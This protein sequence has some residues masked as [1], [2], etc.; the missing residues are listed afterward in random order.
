MT[1]FLLIYMYRIK[2]CP[3]VRSKKGQSLFVPVR[4][5]CSVPLLNFMDNYLPS[6]IL[7]QYRPNPPANICF[8][9]L[10]FAFYLWQGRFVLFLRA[11]FVF[12][13]QATCWMFFSPAFFKHVS[14]L[15]LVF[16]YL[17]SCAFFLMVGLNF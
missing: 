3:N 6:R 1:M 2:A 15:I 10:L 9:L 8:K 7:P 13:C 4:V 5:V 17:S 14:L 12:P 11:L 16:I